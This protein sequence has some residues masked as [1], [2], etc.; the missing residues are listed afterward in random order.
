M[1]KN[2]R[3]EAKV[4]FLE[5]LF[6]IARIVAIIWLAMNLWETYKPP[7]QLTPNDWDLPVKIEVVK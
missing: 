6:W 2:R 5:M 1:R 7:V 4:F 3:T